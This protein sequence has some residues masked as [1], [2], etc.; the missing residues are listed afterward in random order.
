M[1]TWWLGTS[2]PTMAKADLLVGIY[3][4]AGVSPENAGSVTTYDTDR[5]FS[6]ESLAFAT[7]LQDDVLSAMN[8]QGW[9]IPNDGVVSDASEGSLA[10]NPADGGLAAQAADYDHLLLLGPAEAGYFTTPSQMAGAVIEPLFLTDPSEG[11]IAASAADQAVIAQGIAGAIEQYFAPA[12]TTA[13]RP[14]RGRWHLR[15]GLARAG[16][17]PPVRSPPLTG[18]QQSPL[19][20]SMDIRPPCRLRAV[21]GCARGHARPCSTNAAACG[22]ARPARWFSSG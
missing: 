5:P 2:A 21:R 11:S 1:T 4:D 15:P 16:R 14:W 7:L 9:A 10:G 12:S 18:Q 8:A 17:R 20:R 13:P 6:A 19:V 3:M 22:R